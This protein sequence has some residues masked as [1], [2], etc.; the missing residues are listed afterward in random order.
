M[1]N[2]PLTLPPHYDEFRDVVR[3]LGIPE[4]ELRDVP[5][6][7]VADYASHEPIPPGFPRPDDHIVIADY[8]IDL[9]VIAV[10]CSLASDTYERVLAYAYGDWWEVADSL[11]QITDSL[12][13]YDNGALFGRPEQ[14]T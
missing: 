2:A 12:R 13:V 6:E 10:D 1:A 8:L 5:T 3:S 7:S 14:K 4:L 9:P 11:S